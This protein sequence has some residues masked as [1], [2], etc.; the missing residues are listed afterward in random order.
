M[1][2]AYSRLETRP[3]DV[4]SP[5]EGKA[6]MYAM[7][8]K[9]RARTRMAAAVMSFALV[10]GGTAIQQVVTAPAAQASVWDS[11]KDVTKK[12]RLWWTTV[13]TAAWPANPSDD[14]ASTEDLEAVARGQFGRNGEQV[15]GLERAALQDAAYNSLRSLILFQQNG[16][17]Q[18]LA[19]VADGINNGGRLDG[20]T[21]SHDWYVL[22]TNGGCR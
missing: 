19:L 12:I 5:T 15:E 1:I 3:N 20:L 10:G 18:A 8:R 4:E 21:N 6:N 17:A 9:S 7:A 11:C 2:A 13:E 22:E 14:L 16:R